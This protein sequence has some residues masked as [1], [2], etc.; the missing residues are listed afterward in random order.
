MSKVFLLNDGGF[1]DME[2]A[3][4]PVEVEGV[5]MDGDCF[6]KGHELRRIGG[7]LFD[8]NF[9]YCFNEDEFT[10]IDGEECCRLT[11]EERQLLQNGDYTPEEL[12]GIGGRKTC[13]K[14]YNK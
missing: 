9:P 14:C 4:F 13:P 12:F 1:G 7:K 2:S 11:E 6:V 5:L 10:V 8:S 3:V